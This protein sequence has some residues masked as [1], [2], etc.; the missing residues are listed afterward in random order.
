VIESEKE[1]PLAGQAYLV[2]AGIH[3]KQGKTDQAAR[4][5]Q[6]YRRIQALG[7]RRSPTLR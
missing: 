3:R 7:N 6:E 1:T 5:V 4:E 2:L